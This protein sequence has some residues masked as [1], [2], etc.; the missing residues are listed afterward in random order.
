MFFYRFFMISDA[1]ITIP[2][3]STFLTY[4]FKNNQKKDNFQGKHLY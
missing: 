3:Q 1:Q 2:Q 4:Y